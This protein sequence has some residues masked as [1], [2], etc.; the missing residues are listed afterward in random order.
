MKNMTIEAI[1]EACNGTIHNIGKNE[2]KITVCATSVVIDSRKVTRDGIFIATVG[3][4]VDGHDFI[5]QIFEKGALAAVCEKLP[6]DID[7]G[8]YG[9]CILVEDSFVALKKI[10]AYYRQQLD[11]KVIGITGSVGKTSTKEI[12]ASVVSK[13]YVTHKTQGNFNNEVG[14]PLT[15]LECREDTEVLVLEMGINQADIKAILPNEDK[16]ILLSGNRII[17]L[18]DSGEQTDSCSTEID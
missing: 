11:C 16:V 3:A 4:R 12:I 6:Q 15:V 7:D 5:R 9:V 14:V 17:L 18:K 1:A 2:D 13:R 8:G 10:A